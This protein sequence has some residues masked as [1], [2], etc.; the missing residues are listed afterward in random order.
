MFLYIS[1]E[2]G[3]PNVVREAQATEV[4]VVA[5]PSYGVSEQIE[6]QETGFLEEGSETNQIA[7]LVLELLADTNK[8]QRIG[9][10][11]RSEAHRETDYR[12]IGQELVTELQ[13][14]ARNS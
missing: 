11:A 14:L 3:Y 7:N 9:C 1:Y 10:A 12:T 13:K 8:R 6:H 4:P 5:N 2:D